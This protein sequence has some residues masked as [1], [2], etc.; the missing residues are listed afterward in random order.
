MAFFFPV[1]FTGV[2]MLFLVIYIMKRGGFPA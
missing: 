2:L 1:V